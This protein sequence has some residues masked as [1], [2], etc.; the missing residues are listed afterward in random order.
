MDSIARCCRALL[1]QWR[2]GTFRGDAAAQVIRPRRMHP[3]CAPEN[4]Q[5]RFTCRSADRMNHTLNVRISAREACSCRCCRCRMDPGQAAA[6][7]CQQSRPATAPPPPAEPVLAARR[8][9]KQ[10]PRRS[11]RGSASGARGSM[12]RPGRLPFHGAR[13]HSDGDTPWCCSWTTGAVARLQRQAR[14]LATHARC[15]RQ[16]AGGG[17]AGHT[18]LHLNPAQRRR[19]LGGPLC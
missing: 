5:K 1:R 14:A 18:R 6:P 4:V 11:L 7:R 10:L 13:G 16:R 19:Y 15:S 17:V 2:M 3:T 8:R 9:T 12:T